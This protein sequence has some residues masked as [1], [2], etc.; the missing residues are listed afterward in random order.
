M[1]QVTPATFDYKKPTDPQVERINAVR[2]AYKSV[3]GTIQANCPAGRNLA[4]AVTELEYGCMRAV[5]AIVE[6]E[7][8]TV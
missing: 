8:V 2:E 5:K 1:S 7:T 6:A 4:L 3:L